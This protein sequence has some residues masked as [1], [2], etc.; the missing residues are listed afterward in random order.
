MSERVIVI[1]AGAGGLACAAILARRGADV[2]L[3]ERATHVGGKLRSEEVAGRAIDAGP[4]VLTMRHV[5]ERVFELA[6]GRLE[7]ALV[8]RPLEV[9]ARHFWPDGSQ[10]DLFAD[11]ARSADAIGRLCGAREARGYL[12]F[13]RYAER[14]FELVR[15][16]FLEAQRPTMA[17]MLARAGRLGPRAMFDID[18]HRTMQAALSTFFR[19]PRLLQLFG[20]YATYCGSSPF[21]APGTLNVIAHVEKMGVFTVQ[22][23]MRRVAEA[24][25]EL[26]TRAG[27]KTWLGAHVSEIVVHGGRVRGVR[28]AD[29]G[30]LEADRVVH[31]GDVSAL[32][33]G[34]LGHGARDA[35]PETTHPT[36]SAITAAAVADAGSAPLERHNVFFSSDYR[37]E[38]R[39][40]EAGAAPSDPTIYLCAQDRDGDAPRTA[41]P[42]RMFFIVNAPPVRRG[43]NPILEETWRKRIFEIV[44]SFGWPLDPVASVITT[45]E[46]FA[47]RFPGTQGSI[48][49]PASVG[50]WSSFAKAEARSGLAGLYLC[51]GS[52]HPGAG[53]PMAAT[54]GILAAQAILEDRPSTARSKKAAIFGGTW[55]R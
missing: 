22:G 5:F 23:G 40:I 30:V 8:L 16:P 39:E 52:V 7:D 49:G 3:L 12:D 45:P 29:G 18:G 13:S 54:S 26:A 50:M 14:I 9:L 10:L 27:A 28:L 31:N 1:G 15:E 55:T 19:D 44:S 43:G 38:F 48:Y 11:T 32:S 34:L 20:R 46:T 17:G 42:E 37:R 6:G 2:T 35:A 24:L 33:L 21:S 36:L 25:H 53:V 51:G 41:G 4:T 47:A